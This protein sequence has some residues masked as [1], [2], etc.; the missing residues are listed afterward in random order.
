MDMCVAGT[1]ATIRAAPGKR[2][3]GGVMRGTVFR[4]FAMCLCIVVSG[5]IFDDNNDDSDQTPDTLNGLGIGTVAA[6]YFPMTPGVVRYYTENRTVSN[7]GKGTSSTTESYSLKCISKYIFDGTTYA[8]E[9]DGRAPDESI[10]YWYDGNDVYRIMP[11]MWLKVAGTDVPDDIESPYHDLE[12]DMVY[13]RFNVP[14]G[15]SWTIL[16]KHRTYD[17]SPGNYFD[18]RITCTY[19]GMETVKIDMGVFERCMTFEYTTIEKYRLSN[20]DD[21]IEENEITTTRHVWFA[22]DVGLVRD[23][24]LVT[25][26]DG[27]EATTETVLTAIAF[28]GA[29][30][31][32]GIEGYSVSGRIVDWDGVGVS[33]V[34]VAVSGE[35]ISRSGVTA[36]NGTFNIGGLTQGYYELIAAHSGLS[37]KPSGTCFSIVESDTY[38]GVFLAADDQTSAT[39]PAGPLESYMQFATGATWRYTMTDYRDTGE[40][41]EPREV[42]YECNGEVLH[43]ENGGRYVE[44]SLEQGNDTEYYAMRNGEMYC[45]YPEIRYL[46]MVGKRAAVESDTV[47]GENFDMDTSEALYYSF[48]KG[49]GTG[50][51]IASATSSHD[52]SYATVCYSAAFVGL[53]S[54][55]TGAGVFD[56]C[57]KFELYW[58]EGSQA[59]NFKG[60]DMYYVSGART[61]IVT[62]WFAY[63]V[64][65]VKEEVA[66]VEEYD[67]VEEDGTVVLEPGRFQLESTLDLEAS[68]IP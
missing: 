28:D 1:W 55:D 4:L 56:D 40:P 37:I 63:G 26:G 45:Y 25:T 65:M 62:R 68:T 58:Q 27:Y 13:Q 36:D 19:T 39:V 20:G 7:A 22:P 30:E 33:G 43:G 2:Y 8:R 3:V 52:S 17:S 12:R 61:V 16:D 67:S 38:L 32:D 64:G 9:I 11:Y 29:Y 34:S 21:E 46:A 5:C 42:I 60:G 15:T 35:G 48:D 10:N 50:W 51:G 44:L 49:A 54:V 59:D 57:A 14:V 41:Y 23:N 47:F 66:R 6:T 31:P 53:E 24:E 18:Y